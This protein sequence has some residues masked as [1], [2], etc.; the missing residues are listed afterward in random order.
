MVCRTLGL[1]GAARKL[2]PSI[3]GNPQTPAGQPLFVLKSLHCTGSERSLFECEM[4]AWGGHDDCTD[5]EI[6]SVACASST[7]NLQFEPDAA[8]AGGAIAI[9]P[10]VGSEVAVLSTAFGIVPVCAWSDPEAD[11]LC[12]Q[13]G[14]ACG[15]LN[16]TL[17]YELPSPPNA[18]GL[19]AGAFAAVTCA[20]GGR[21][22]GILDCRVRLLREC[23]ASAR[24]L[25]ATLWCLGD[26]AEEKDAALCRMLRQG[27]ADG[28]SAEQGV[29]PPTKLTL[30]LKTTNDT[31]A[32]KC[33]EEETWVFIG[34]G[35]EGERIP[36]LH[37]QA[38]ELQVTASVTYAHHYVTDRVDDDAEK[39]C[40][41]R[42]AGDS[43]AA[44]RKRCRAALAEAACG[45]LPWHLAR[46][47]P[48]RK[49]CEGQGVGCLARIGAALQA[50]ADNVTV[51]EWLVEREEVKIGDAAELRRRCDCLADCDGA[52]SYTQTSLDRR[53]RA[54]CGEPRPGRVALTLNRRASIRYLR[55]M[56]S[57][58]EVVLGTVGGLMSIFV[59]FSFICIVELFYFF[60]LRDGVLTIVLCSSQGAGQKGSV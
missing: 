28:E 23:P 13:R 20:G 19:L 48:G 50:V 34:E 57:T 49:V 46:A 59:G 30:E 55:R 7:D 29:V 44:C 10:P 52:V 16:R 47:R 12:R 1:G 56:V 53:V 45:C 21:E 60:T 11:V 22:E 9:A 25:A 8:L 40:T 26:D 43:L 24:G 27:N 39:G 38:V 17:E 4:G 36:V 15:M 3:Y 37:N 6:L 33:E 18:L 51:A 2:P 54:A 31:N 42:R 35:V 58:W 5:A 14:H 32:A 41:R